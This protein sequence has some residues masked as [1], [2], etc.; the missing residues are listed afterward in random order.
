MTDSMMPGDLEEP[1]T[2][3]TGIGG[4]RSGGENFEELLGT[5]PLELSVELGRVTLTLKDI[6]MRL[7]PGSVIE[8]NKLAGE[9]LDVR[10]NEHL[11]AH[12]EAVAVGERYGIRIVE[13]VTD[14]EER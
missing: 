3:G 5:V 14:K 11:V 6:A 4:G 10:V 8:L 12:A 2:D 13:I 7:G 1:M 9:T